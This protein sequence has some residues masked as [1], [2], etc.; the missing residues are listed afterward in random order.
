MAMTL[1]TGLEDINQTSVYIPFQEADRHEESYTLFPD[2]DLPNGFGLRLTAYRTAW[3][4]CL[5]RIQELILALHAPVVD[6]VVELVK[7]AYTDVLPGLPYT[8][9]PIIS[10]TASGTS[11]SIFD[12]ISSRL[13]TEGQDDLF[14]DG[15]SAHIVTRIFPS[16]CPNI[17][18][19]MKTLI[20]GFINKTD[21]NLGSVKR[22]PT[23]SLSTIDI[24]LLQ[25]WF[26]ALCVARGT[27]QNTTRL[28]VILHDFEQFE[29]L[30][31]QDLFE[32]CSLAIP[33][34]PLVFVLSLTSPPSPSYIHA[35]YPR[36][37]LSR[38]QVRSCPFPSSQNILHDILLK[39]F[40]DVGFDPHLMLGHAAINFLIDFFG[41]HTTSLDGLV[42]ALQ[43]AHMKHFEDPLT[44]FLVDETA[45]WDH[46]DPSLFAFLDS[47]FA[48]V[49]SSSLI[50]DNSME[51]LNQGL[52]ELLAS[53]RTARAA[54]QKRSKL[55]RVSF[56][57]FL[58]VQRFM[59]SL[60]H[61]SDKTLPELM[62]GAL[63]G[64]LGNS[65][66]YLCTMVKKLRA[67]QLDEL[68]SDLRDFFT[69][70][71]NEVQEEERE[72]IARID[73]A[74]SIFTGNQSEAQE[75]QDICD[76]L[77]DWLYEYFQQ[78]LLSLE[79]SPL[80]DIWYTG[81]TPFPSE[82]LNPSLRASVLSGLLHPQDYST[83][84]IINGDDDDEVLL[85]MPDTTIVFQRYL[86]T[87]KMINIYDWFESFSIVLEA[88]RRRARTRGLSEDARTPSCREGKQRQ[89]E[90]VEDFP[91]ESEEDLE[92]WKMESQARFIRALHELDYVGLIKHTGRKADHVMRTVF[93]VPG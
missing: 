60:G 87:G 62:C 34:L 57:L 30:V 84:T 81:S 15:N 41:R 43:L 54:F 9:L 12:E 23:T 79:E 44:I 10:V 32:V 66:K 82:L 85:D 27:D 53:V 39:T 8:E 17:T 7:D 21:E 70:V 92:K 88:Q 93:D 50:P 89:T 4:K 19:A 91:E 52:D 51:W 18:S 73:T 37:T 74:R 65:S 46:R 59:I 20:T 29:P 3:S 83:A 1:E 72:V 14:G 35:T 75:A 13:E 36:S 22:K 55:L 80:W 42:S 33:R 61:K 77:G 11:P 26:D 63:R 58:L 6:K 86:E 25:L 68:L 2:R 28:V 64:R 38:L 31:I 71:S 5:E 78:R 49:H 48:R 67:D 76:S 16:N 69:S 90:V 40:F 24:N 56:Q 45:G 47:V